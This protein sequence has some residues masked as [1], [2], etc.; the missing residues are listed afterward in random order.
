MASWRYVV[1]F[2]KPFDK[3][4]RTFIGDVEPVGFVPTLRTVI[5]SAGLD[6]LS[7]FDFRQERACSFRL[8]LRQLISS[9]VVN[10]HRLIAFSELN[11]VTKILLA[12]LVHRVL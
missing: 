7:Y 2:V 8:D 6:G 1:M 4:C 3:C 9:V 12:I 11:I 10:W 5:R